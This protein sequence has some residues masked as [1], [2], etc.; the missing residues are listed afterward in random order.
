MHVWFSGHS[1]HTEECIPISA[2]YQTT[3]LLSAVRG[4]SRGFVDRSSN[5]MPEVVD[6]GCRKEC[7]AL[8]F[9]TGLPSPAL[10][11][12]MCGNV[13]NR[14]EIISDA[15]WQ[16]SRTFSV[17]L[18]SALN[19]TPSIEP[20]CYNLFRTAYRRHETPPP[21]KV[22]PFNNIR[23]DILAGLMLPRNRP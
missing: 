14:N 6:K 3:Y 5:L 13:S 11:P 23:M 21:V 9:T 12:S 15:P 4:V 7:A 16:Y 1:Q 17:I 22:T 8:K 20:R 19:R 10:L 18:Y 2:T